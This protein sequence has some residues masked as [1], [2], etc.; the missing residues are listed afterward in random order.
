MD[1][2]TRILQGFS[3]RILQQSED[4]CDS[5]VNFFGGIFK[6]L[7]RILHGF[8]KPFFLPLLVEIS[9]DPWRIFGIYKDS[10]AILSN[11]LGIVRDLWRILGL[12]IG[13]LVIF[14]HFMAIP[15]DPW[16]I[17]GISRDSL[18][19]LGSS[20]V[21]L[22]DLWRILGIYEDSLAILNHFKAIPRD[23]WRIFGVSSYSLAILSN[24]LGILRDP[25]RI[26]GICKDS[27]TTATKSSRN[28]KGFHEDSSDLPSASP[29][30]LEGS[31]R[32]ASSI[33]RRFA[34]AAGPLCGERSR[35][36]NSLID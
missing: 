30:A 5:E 12:S 31:R 20:L 27:L 3:A 36:T 21:I 1:K 9:K 33:R 2:S 25:W 14:H 15:R 4:F 11:A 24:S 10:L 19:I 13:S 16:R 8:Q 23:P 29:L 22:R 28:L 18:A 35:E 6:D 7:S 34:A 26:L 32:N 17:F